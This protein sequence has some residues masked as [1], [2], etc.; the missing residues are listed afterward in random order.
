MAKRPLDDQI[1]LNAVRQRVLDD[2]NRRE[3]Q[4]Q[5]VNNVY[6]GGGEGKGHVPMRGVAEQLGDMG[7]EDPYDYFVDI[8]RRDLDEMNPHTGKP[9]GWTKNVHR[10]RKKKVTGSPS[11]K[12]GRKDDV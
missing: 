5:I 6:G 2:L 10:F 12:K 11:S 1:L 9:S 3:Q 8:T 4:Q 7:E